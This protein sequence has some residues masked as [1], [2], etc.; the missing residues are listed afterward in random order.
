[1]IARP[2]NDGSYARCVLIAA[3]L[4]GVRVM[5][6]DPVL[7]HLHP[8]A[9]QQGTTVAVIA[10]GKFDPWPVQVWVDAPGIV[11]KPGKTAGK[12]DVEI[13]KDAP[14]GPHLV[15]CHHERGVS[16][17]R[18]FIVSRDAQT[19][20]S[21]PNDLFHSP[22]K[23][24]A[25]PCSI[26]GRLDKSGDVD[27]FAVTLKRG[28]SLVAWAEAYVL[29]S[30]FD[31]MLRVVGEKG[32]VLAFNHDGR[33]LDPFLAWE[34]PR[35]GTFVVQ[36]MGFVY[37]ATAGVGFTGGE[38]CVYRLH[39]AGGPFVTSTAPLAVQRGKKTPVALHGWNLGSAHAEIDATGIAPGVPSLEFPAGGVLSHLPVL[40][41]DMAEVIEK[42]P[43]DAASAAQEIEIPSGI[44]GTIGRAN[45]EDRFAFHAVKGRAYSIRV[46]AAQIGSPLDAWIAI[47]NSAGKK[48]AEN[49]DMSGFRDPAL[50]W[51]APSDGR[52]VLAIGDLAHHGGGDF[53]YRVSVEEAVPSVNGTT[54][55]HSLS[56]ATGG[57]GEM[58]VAV[59]REVGFQPKLQLIAK[60]L[61]EG[62]TAAPVDV[63]AKDGDVVLKFSA[64][65]AAAPVS[66]PFALALREA[67]SGREHPVRHSLVATSENNGVPQGYTELVIRS[68]EQLW[69]TLFAE[70][71]KTQPAD[72]AA[73]PD[74]P[75][76]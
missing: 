58:K 32:T 10:S 2:W 50:R 29:A 9:G 72:A 37:P 1:M 64:D 11:F 20:E 66:Q 35:D 57:G 71:A 38:G 14:P 74:A 40:V 34:A 39:L 63:P 8:V 65:A 5:A 54:A 28:Q 56:I 53:V 69:L 45:D 31:G 22:K 70:P 17:P 42:E 13:A 76:R 4:L 68:T 47:S 59:K 24:A 46:T 3:L 41:S 75:A 21:E 67:E 62:V 36:M 18:F 7:N 49:D 52:H 23:I 30:T 44:T 27:S 48:L 73:K 26:A 33:T 61:P 6:A 60:N 51:T 25:L 55:A 12:F 15:R 16:A 43:N 19:A